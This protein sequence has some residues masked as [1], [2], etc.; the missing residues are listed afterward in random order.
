MTNK[1]TLMFLYLCIDKEQSR[2]FALLEA[3]KPVSWK[4]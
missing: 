2:T 1:T 4:N 3:L